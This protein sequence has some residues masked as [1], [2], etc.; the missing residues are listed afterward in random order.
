MRC[1]WRPGDWLMMLLTFAFLWGI[2][3]GSAH[4]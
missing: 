1:R 4:R 3:L 2:I